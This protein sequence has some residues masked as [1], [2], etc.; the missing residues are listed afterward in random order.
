MLP[1][2]PRLKIECHKLLMEAAR[3]A[4]DRSMAA[5]GGNQ[6]AVAHFEGNKLCIRRADGSESTGSYMHSR[7]TIS[8]NET[9]VL[10]L[11]FA[12]LLTKFTDLGTAMGD[13]QFKTA[14][15]ALERTLSGTPNALKH[16]KD[17]YVTGIFQSL[18]QIWLE[19]DSEGHPIFPKLLASPRVAAKLEEALR[20]IDSDPILRAKHDH[21]VA[22]K[23]EEWRDREADRKL[24]G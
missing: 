3:S 20:Q 13:Q 22:T 10:N 9:E 12:E 1:D 11:S 16:P 23:K 15:D 4:H 8:V 21:L 19:F 14:I 18:E 6:N 2:Y 17:D 5:F 24:V 7:H